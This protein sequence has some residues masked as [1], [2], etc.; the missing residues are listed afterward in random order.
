MV[1]DDRLFGFICLCVRAA[2]SGVK[3]IKILDNKVTDEITSWKT[4]DLE[5]KNDFHPLLPCFQP[6]YLISHV[7]QSCNNIYFARR[8]EAP[9]KLLPPI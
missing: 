6:R 1:I 4:T 2:F 5:E 3:T 8:D 9:S 7:F